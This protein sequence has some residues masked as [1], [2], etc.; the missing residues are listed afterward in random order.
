[1]THRSRITI[2]PTAQALPLDALKA[3]LRVTHDA[4]DEL[5]L[6]ALA[7]AVSYGEHLTNRQWLQA[8]R[9]LT[10]DAWP[11]RLAWTAYVELPFPPLQRVESVVYV[12]AAGETQTMVEGVDYVVD[13]SSGTMPARLYR[14]EAWPQTV[15]RPGAVSITYVCGF[16]QTESPEVAVLPPGIVA[17]LKIRVADLYAQR[18]SLAMESRSQSFVE[19]PRSYVDGLLDPWIVPGGM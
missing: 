10:L 14:G 18:E 13:N 2:A 3:H 5:I 1:M 6:A 15:I 19:L 9:V 11:S 8:T 16:P 17:W 4:E 12:D 7:A